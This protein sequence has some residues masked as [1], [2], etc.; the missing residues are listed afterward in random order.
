MTISGCSREAELIGALRRGELPAELRDHALACESCR[1][2]AAISIWMNRMAAES[3]PATVP[4][5]ALLRLKASLMQQRRLE[6]RALQPLHALQWIAYGAI[7]LAWA[8]VIT[9]KWGVIQRFME[10]FSLSGLVA[11][12]AGASHVSLSSILMLVMLACATVV[13]TMHTVFAEE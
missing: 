9:W 8:A 11:S 13:V 1:E 12:S 5:P 10:T 2:A 4:D 3:R 7:A 6:Q